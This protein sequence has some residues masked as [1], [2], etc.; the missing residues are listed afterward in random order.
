MG[1]PAWD[2]HLM[3]IPQSTFHILDGAEIYICGFTFGTGSVSHFILLWLNDQKIF[4][5]ILLAGIALLVRFQQFCVVG[6]AKLSV[7]TFAADLS[8]ESGCSRL[9]STSST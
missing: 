7:S 4:H 9:G 1:L 8:A 5:H 6:C 2:E 3:F